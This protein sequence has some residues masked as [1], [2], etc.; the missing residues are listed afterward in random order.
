MRETAEE[1]VS[2]EWFRRLFHRTWESVVLAI[3]E[4]REIPR[5][6]EFTGT[7][8]SARARSRIW[9]RMIHGSLRICEICDGSVFIGLRVSRVWNKGSLNT[10]AQT[11][12]SA[13]NS[14]R[15]SADRSI[16][17]HN[18]LTTPNFR[19]LED[20]SIQ[21]FHDTRSISRDQVICSIGTPRC[22]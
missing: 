13:T 21:K 15:I 6:S 7:R 8:S 9:S 11:E 1:S 18:Q 10:K 19:T 14:T 5:E 3:C 12:T 4:T 17:L 20:Q 2:W 22:V 16:N